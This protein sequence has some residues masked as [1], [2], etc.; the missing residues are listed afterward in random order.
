M[1][2][3]IEVFADHKPITDETRAKCRVFRESGFKNVEVWV[4][5]HLVYESPKEPTK[6]E[7]ETQEAYAKLETSS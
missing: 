2:Q 5:D 1:E 6:E 7:L 4:N 3:D